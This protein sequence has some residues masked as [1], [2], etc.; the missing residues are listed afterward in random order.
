LIQGD[1]EKHRADVR[2]K[3][4]NATPWGGKRG[5][6]GVGGM[7]GLTEYWR[8]GVPGDGETATTDKVETQPWGEDL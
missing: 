8:L 1:E 4:E 3:G 6:R 5:V 7:V 2:P